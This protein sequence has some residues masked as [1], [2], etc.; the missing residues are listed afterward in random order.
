MATGPGRRLVGGITNTPMI[1]GWWYLATVI[2]LV[3]REV[4]GFAMADHHRAEL[5]IDDLTMA[6]GR[7]D[8]KPGCVMRTDRGNDYT[9]REFRRHIK[10]LNLRQSMGRAGTGC[11]RG[12]PRRRLPLHRGRVQLLT[13][14]S[15]PWAPLRRETLDRVLIPNEAHAG[16]RTTATL[17]D[18][19]AQPRLTAPNRLVERPRWD[20][21]ACLLAGVFLL[22][23][24]RGAG[25]GPLRCSQVLDPG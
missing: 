13:S 5:V 24:A 11:D 1:E 15:E 8:P 25:T 4:I 16:S 7:A 10:E 3:T 2:D 21:V 20:G 6:A 14:A 19:K 22:G 9:S 18:R 12:G 17:P 23:P